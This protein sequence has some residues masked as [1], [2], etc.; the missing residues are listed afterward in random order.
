M[1]DDLFSFRKNKEIF[2]LNVDLKSK[3]IQF[4]DDDQSNFR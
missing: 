1:E 2:I 4:I 3:E